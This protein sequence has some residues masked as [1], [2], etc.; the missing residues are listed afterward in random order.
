MKIPTGYTKVNNEP[1]L[2]ED[3]LEIA[4]MPMLQP[5]LASTVKTQEVHGSHWEAEIC[6]TELS[7]SD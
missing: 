6:R 7:S 2:A 4:H 1:S 3:G 5:I